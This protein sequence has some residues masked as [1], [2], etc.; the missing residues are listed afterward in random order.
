[1]VLYAFGF[2]INSRGYAFL[3]HLGG[4]DFDHP[5][6]SMLCVLKDAGGER[7]W[8]LDSIMLGHCGVTLS[9]VNQS[10][11]GRFFK[12]VDCPASESSMQP[13]MEEVVSRILT[14]TSYI[15]DADGV[16]GVN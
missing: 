11:T 10:K 4:L 16:E 6:G 7:R 15:A 9:C 1:M 13:I 14:F 2:L 12:T 5:L 8:C 3:A